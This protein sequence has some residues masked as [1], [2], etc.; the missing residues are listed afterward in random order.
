MEKGELLMV[1]FK[2]SEK[3]ITIFNEEILRQKIVPVVINH[4]FQGNGQELW[5]ECIKRNCTDFVLVNISNID[6]NKEMTPWKQESFSKENALFL[7]EA[8]SYIEKFTHQIFP[9]IEKYLEK[10]PSYYIISGYSLAGLF[11]IYSLYKTDFFLGAISGSG[12][13]WYPHFVEF[14]KEN[15]FIKK[16]RKIYFSLGN[17]EK[18]TKKDLLKTVQDCTETICHYYQSKEIDVFYELNEGGHFKE[19]DFRM[20]KGIQWMISSRD[21]W[22]NK[23]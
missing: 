7:G 10:K 16:P 9:K 15:E 1:E 21:S 5:E 18:N 3:Q 8:D 17:K 2:A 22:K 12:S 19:V 14:I 23:E 20:A 11:A 6:W 13:F 4:T